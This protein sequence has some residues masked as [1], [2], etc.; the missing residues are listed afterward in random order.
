[1]A[2]TLLVSH[3]D[4]EAVSIKSAKKKH[5]QE[6]ALPDWQRHSNG[7]DKFDDDD[8]DGR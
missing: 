8:D 3:E 2:G 5:H 1:M 7:K 6:G 4:N